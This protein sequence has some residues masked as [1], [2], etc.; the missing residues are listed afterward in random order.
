M[1]S[2]Q[3]DDDD[4]DLREEHYT[5]NDTAPHLL[6][7]AALPPFLRARKCSLPLERQRLSVIALTTATAVASTSPYFRAHNMASYPP[8]FTGGGPHMAVKS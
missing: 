2:A 8:T 3:N 1:Q 6:T 5:A 4:D 7:A